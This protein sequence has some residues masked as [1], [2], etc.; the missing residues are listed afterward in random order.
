MAG[1]AFPG[2]GIGLKVWAPKRAYGLP[3]GYGNSILDRHR[4]PRPHP[5]PVADRRAG[6]RA[7][8]GLRPHCSPVAAH[9]HREGLHLHLR[10]D[11]ASARIRAAGD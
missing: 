3:Q 7:V 9:R 4:L 2:A 11:G 10:A 6:G 1:Q 8:W 5:R